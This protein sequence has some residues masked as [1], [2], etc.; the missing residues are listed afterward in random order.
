ME[1]GTKRWI[2][3]ITAWIAGLLVGMTLV[4][5]EVMA[6]ASLPAGKC[7]VQVQSRHADL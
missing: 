7:G 3:D 1:N 6:G 4:A 5:H 2:L